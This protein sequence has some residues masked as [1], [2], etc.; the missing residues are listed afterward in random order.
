MQCDSGRVWFEEQEISALGDDKLSQL[1][2]HSMGFIFQNSLLLDDFTALENVQIPS[3]IAGKSEKQAKVL[4]MEML[5]TVGMQ[6]RLH[7][8][9][10]QLSGGE[11]QRVAIARALVNAPSVIFADEPTGSLDEQ[12]ASLVEDLLFSLVQQQQVALMLITHNYSF[13]QRCDVV[14]HLHDRKVEVSS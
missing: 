10:D 13:A 14:Y 6:D 11:R 7:H 8:T 5:T 9:S 12:N 3:M 2:S 1:R 4:A